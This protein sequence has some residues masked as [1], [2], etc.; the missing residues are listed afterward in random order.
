MIVLATLY[1]RSSLKIA[2]FI[3]NQLDVILFFLSDITSKDYTISALHSFKI[4]NA[5]FYFTIII[6]PSLCN[7]ECGTQ[8]TGILLVVT[9][10]AIFHTQTSLFPV[11]IYN[12]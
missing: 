9:A 2:R 6:S 11:P 3:S 1:H 4:T 10:A 12:H 7:I 8:L 5:Q